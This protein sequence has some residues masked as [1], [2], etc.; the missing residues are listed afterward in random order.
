MA[1]KNSHNSNILFEKGNQHAVENSIVLVYGLHY[2]THQDVQRACDIATETYAKKILNWPN[3]RL[4]KPEIFKA[5]SPD[6]E[7]KDLDGCIKRFVC[8]L[9]DVFDASPPKDLPTYPHAFV[10]MDKN[11]LMADATAT[12][13]LAHKP[14][15]KWTVQ[16]CSVPIEVELDLA[17]ESLRLGD[18]TETDMLDQFTN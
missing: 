8:H 9:H 13:V 10:V 7:L 4:E 11:C 1:S 2:V 18:V 6:E 16:H 17:V 14:D 15:D 3:G 5:E 12:L